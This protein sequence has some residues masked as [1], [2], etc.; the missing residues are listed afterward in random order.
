MIGYVFA[1]SE[2]YQLKR[3]S[4]PGLGIGWR[5]V[6]KQNNNFYFY[7]WFGYDNTEFKNISGY[8]TYRFNSVL[9]G[10]HELVKDKLTLQYWLYYF[11]SLEDGTNYIWRI[12][13]SLL[14][15]LTKKLSVSIN[16]E[17]HFENIVDPLN[18]KWNSVLFFGFQFQNK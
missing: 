10:R 12:E 13:P 7:G 15:H 11:H 3:R 9:Y 8:N 14:F 16:L 2:F 6:E 17:S 4:E 5:M 18:T 1:L